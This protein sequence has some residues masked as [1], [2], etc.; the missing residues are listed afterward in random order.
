MKYATSSLRSTV[1]FFKSEVDY[2]IE[3]E[4]PDCRHC[5]CSG[6][7]F[8]ANTGNAVGKRVYFLQVRGDQR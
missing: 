5:D 1:F 2:I 8:E 7:T 3:P 4:Q 6:T